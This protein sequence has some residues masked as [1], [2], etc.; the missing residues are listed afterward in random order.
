MVVTAGPR[1]LTFWY[2]MYGSGMGSL[3]VLRNDTQ[4]WTRSG[5][6]GNSWHRAE[7]DIGTVGA[8][9]RVHIF[10]IEERRPFE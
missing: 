6:Q 5:D 2:H 7:I 4:V 1:C 3:N 10:Y 9:Y 8:N